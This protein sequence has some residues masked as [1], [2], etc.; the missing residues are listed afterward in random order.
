MQEVYQCIFGNPEG[1]LATVT[2]KMTRMDE[3]CKAFSTSHTCEGET[4]IE[5]LTSNELPYKDWPYSLRE[6]NMPYSGKW[7][8]WGPPAV[9]CGIWP[10]DR[11]PTVKLK[12][13]VKAFLKSGYRTSVTFK[14]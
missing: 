7:Q 11:I 10:N 5:D 3:T 2:D 14:I 4:W 1:E 6:A 13:S 9:T 12:I 8:M